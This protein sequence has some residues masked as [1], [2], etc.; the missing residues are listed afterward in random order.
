MTIHRSLRIEGSGTAKLAQ[1][2]ERLGYNTDTKLERATVLEP[3]PNMRIRMNS[4]EIEL[5]RAFLTVTRSAANLKVGEQALV[6]WDEREQFCV[7]LDEI[8]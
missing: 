3:M 5:D 4:D 2:I 8:I 1:V 7:V 6:A